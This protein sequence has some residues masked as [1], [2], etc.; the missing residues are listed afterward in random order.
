M[1]KQNKKTD[2]KLPIKK[3]FW[4]KF[5]FIFLIALVFVYL[6]SAYF[7]KNY[8]PNIRVMGV[9]LKG[10]NKSEAKKLLKAKQDKLLAKQIVVLKEEGEPIKAVLKDVGF[11]Y[12]LDEDL[13]RLYSIFSAPQAIKNLFCQS[14]N[15]TKFGIKVDEKKINNFLNQRVARV[16][17]DPT[18][19]QVYVEGGVAKVREGNPGQKPDLVKLKKDII[20]LNPESRKEFLFDLTFSE[21]P[22][23]PSDADYIKKAMKEIDILINRQIVFVFEEKKIVADRSTVGSWL[24]IETRNDEVKFDFNPDKMWAYVG[25]LNE[26]VAIAPVNRLLNAKGEVLDEGSDG[27]A[28]EQN[29]AYA[30]IQSGLSQLYSEFLLLTVVVPKGESRLAPDDGPTPGMYAGKY[31]EIDLSQQMLYIIEGNRVDGGFSVSSGAWDM[32][33]PVGTFS[34]LSKATMAWSDISFVWMPWWMQFTGAGHGIHELPIWPDG[35]REGENALGW[36]VSHGCVRLGIGSAETVFNWTPE[37]I[38][39]VVHN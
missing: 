8:Y 12:D 4:Q 13:N 30:K 9:E 23:A 14:C 26:Q 39:V 11:Y 7:Y 31:I 33:T 22:P 17:S 19:P 2:L 6:V 1:E 20:A 16:A 21:M 24:S 5:F 3:K 10:V 28:L 36:A 27:R 38:P 32:P 37:G 18:L 35:T 25:Y 29:D 34:V 15:L